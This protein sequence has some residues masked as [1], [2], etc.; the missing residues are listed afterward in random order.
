MSDSSVK[1]FTPGQEK[2]GTWIINNLGKWQTRVYEAS[3]GRLWNTFLGGP[4]AILT[5][6]GRKTG[7][8]R[9]TITR[10]KLNAFA[11]EM[12]LVDPRAIPLDFIYR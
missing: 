10:R 2:F 6:T 9:K 7:K 5:V 11:I 12:N 8:Q 3:G 4:V 1:P